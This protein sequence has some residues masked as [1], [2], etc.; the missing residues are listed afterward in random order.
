[1]RLKLLALAALLPLAA[2]GPK[3]SDPVT[4]GVTDAMIAAGNGDS[5]LTYGGDYAEQRFS[6]LTQIS[7]Q[8]VGQLGLTWSADLDTARGQEATPLMH[9]GVLYVTTAW[10]T[11]S[12]IPLNRQHWP[13]LDA[14]VNPRDIRSRQMASRWHSSKI[15]CHKYQAQIP[16]STVDSP[17]VRYW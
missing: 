9:G 17:I 6:P 1:M 11:M 5:W 10:S 8:N 3:A 13:A 4:E 2:C 12:V 16:S 7:D 15:D 14:V